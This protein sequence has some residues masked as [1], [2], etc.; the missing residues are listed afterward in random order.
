MDERRGKSGSRK[1]E[2]SDP[3]CSPVIK[4]FVENHC[5]EGDNWTLTIGYV[6]ILLE[7][8]NL[9]TTKGEKVF[10]YKEKVEDLRAA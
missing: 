6:K 9:L 5:F 4:D 3:S 10:L 7:Y 1:I 8:S 2:K